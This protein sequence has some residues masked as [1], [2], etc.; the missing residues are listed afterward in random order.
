MR[1]ATLWALEEAAG[2]AFRVTPCLLSAM[3]A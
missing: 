2:L 1:K 3:L